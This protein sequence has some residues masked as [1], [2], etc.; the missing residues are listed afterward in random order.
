MAC[1]VTFY[2]MKRFLLKFATI[3]LFSII[4]IV[5]FSP[6]VYAETET[7]GA[8]QILILHSYHQGFNWTDNIMKGIRSV[9]DHD[10]HYRYNVEYMDFRRFE[11]DQYKK[12][13][14][15]LY[16]YKYEGWKFDAI[17][18]SDDKALNFALDYREKHP[19]DPDTP[20]FFCGITD[21]PESLL[22]QHDNIT[23]V[24]EHTDTSQAAKIA[25][26]L[27]PQTQKIYIIRNDSPNDR[28]HRKRLVADIP[29]DIPI[30]DWIKKDLNE[31]LERLKNLEKNDLVFYLSGPS[32]WLVK[33]VNYESGLQHCNAPIFTCWDTFLRNGILGGQVI[34][35]FHQGKIAATMAKR[36][37]TGEDIHTIPFK[38][39][40]PQSTRF[41]YTVMKKFG[42]TESDLPPG[43]EYLNRPITLYEKYKYIIWALSIFILFESMLIIAYA[44]NRL[45]RQKAEKA[46]RLLTE[47]LRKAQENAHIGNWEYDI[48]TDK[49]WCSEETIRIHGL[50][51]DRS[52]YEY[53]D[54]FEFIFE[55]Y[56]EGIKERF[57]NLINHGTE[58]NCEYQIKRKYDEE[59]RTV[60]SR[61][62]L[63]LDSNNYPQ[64]VS[65]TI[66][67]VTEQKNLE[68]QLLQSQK[69][70]AIGHL[71]G[72]VAHDFNN[73]LTGIIGYSNII[74]AKT[75]EDHEFRNEIEEI[76]K[77]GERAASLTRQLLAFSRKQ[78]LQPK[79]IEINELIK[80]LK[81][82]LQRLIGEHIQIH[83]NL[84]EQIQSIEADPGQIEQVIVN[85]AI[86]ARDAMPDGGQL[87]LSTQYIPPRSD[88]KHLTKEFNEMSYVLIQIRD[89]GYGIPQDM[90]HQIFEPFFTT[91]ETG[92]GLGLSTV[93]GIVKQSNGHIFT[94]ST[95][96]KGTTF[97]LY[98]PS[99]QKKTESIE[100]RSSMRGSLQGTETLLLV[101]DEEIV[102]NLSATLLSDNGYTV[103]I[104]QNGTEAKQLIDQHH[105]SLDLLI[106]DIVLPDINGREVADYFQKIIPYV[107]VLY[108]SGYTDDSS[109]K[110][111]I[112]NEEF[113]YLQKPYSPEMLLTK[114][115]EILTSIPISKKPKNPF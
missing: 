59:I 61:A 42:I 82:M 56:H 36:V 49:F 15:N 114:I 111:G 101:E 96:G 83:I 25:L 67:D 4:F 109:L 32:N 24:F 52:M 113:Y 106:S 1:Y 45:K 31:L 38:T 62:T 103:Y 80:N 77:A 35:S 54:I 43:T 110:N 46:E 44:T 9:F 70:E 37:L 51:K 30:E 47:R 55:E 81:K 112:E 84:D 75:N 89:T 39:K 85:L 20:I 50:P 22:S 11:G 12:T 8:K 66:Q 41:D 94:D 64:K 2:G 95:L 6:P 29:K 97:S 58:F 87:F 115:K 14:L 5:A 107:P 104:A 92:T 3:C 93:Y 65:G 34:S 100:D 53:R 74:L 10:S 60:H 71:A 88:S 18:C 90:Q 98:F 7:N 105:D 16:E 17:I 78:I 21:T 57:N 13:L 79:I 33:M 63:F 73:L 26:Y 28:M 69:M 91:K 68:G 99:C 23:G 72:G 86:N 76:H 40:C 102:R 108:I 19:F 48:N 27:F